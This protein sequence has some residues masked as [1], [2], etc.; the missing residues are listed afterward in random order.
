MSRLI[1][2]FLSFAMLWFFAGCATLP[3]TL[4]V[5]VEPPL[6]ISTETPP[7]TPTPILEPT[8]EQTPTET[9]APSTTPE[10]LPT[11]TVT[12][13]LVVLP[14]TCPLTETAVYVDPTWG[15]CF[16]YPETFMVDDTTAAE[17][18]VTFYGPALDTGDNPS[19]AKLEVSVQPVP[20][21]STLS[22]LVNAFV[23][24]FQYQLP[25]SILRTPVTLGTLAAEKL[26]PA[27]DDNFSYMVLA[28]QETRFITLRF[29]P[30]DTSITQPDLDTIFQRVTGSFTFLQAETLEPSVR[31]LTW[32]EFDRNII[33]EYGS[34]LAPWVYVDT[35]PTAL[36]EG[37][38]EYPFS[39]PPYVEF[40]FVGFQGGREYS[41]P[42]FYNR[43]Q[44]AQIMIFRTADFPGFGA[45]FPDG[46]PAQLQ[47]L[48]DLLETG[49][50]P[51]RCGHV[52]AGD[53]Q[54]LPMLP[55]INAHQ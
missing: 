55:P 40:R 33:L 10:L 35:V 4:E 9:L 12:P 28:V 37:N 6:N 11:P 15:Y 47:T 29:S 39:Q 14:E 21:G 50:D 27:A 48:T 32:P 1:C 46:F 34:D 26:S 38:V 36:L 54:P 51:A 18:V 49:L 8:Q 24:S 13:V 41:L 19:R 17:G 43:S 44:E 52:F 53:N 30:T 22:G 31:T 45:D 5:A 23:D 20:N 16:A 7:P 2:F 25:Q 3:G 42:M